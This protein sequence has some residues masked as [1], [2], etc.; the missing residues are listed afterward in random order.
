MYFPS[1]RLPLPSL[2]PLLNLIH[3][4]P[5]PNVHAFPVLLSASKMSETNTRKKWQELFY[6]NWYLSCFVQNKY[7]EGFA[8]VNVSHSGLCLVSITPAFCPTRKYKI[9]R[10]K[11]KSSSGK[12]PSSKGL[13]SRIW[14]CRLKWTPSWGSVLIAMLS[15]PTNAHV[16]HLQHRWRRSVSPSR[17]LSF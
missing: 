6:K 12:W 17:S 4:V 7:S 1:W 16:Q 3:G 10:Q 2:V 11:K 5:H 15:T 8:A 13:D 9:Q 14:Y